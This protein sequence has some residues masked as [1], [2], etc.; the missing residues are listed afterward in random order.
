MPSPS[1]AVPLLLPF[2]REKGNLRA[3]KET[4]LPKVK[5]ELLDGDGLFPKRRGKA[6][7]CDQLWRRLAKAI[8]C[9][10]A[11]YKLA[12]PSWG[13]KNLSGWDNS[14]T[15]ASQERRRGEAGGLLFSES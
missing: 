6:K 7:A 12:S 11:V 5:P 3:Q 13:G 2:S 1:G 14:R 4:V 10:K 9:L 8:G 15:S